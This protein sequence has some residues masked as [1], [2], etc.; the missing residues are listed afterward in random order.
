M[1]RGADLKQLLSAAAVSVIATLISLLIVK[2]VGVLAHMETITED[3]RV[4][5]IQAPM[6]QSKEIV[7]IG[8]NEET[9][10]RFPYRSPIDRAFLAD[11]LVKLEGKGPLAIGLDILLD[12]AT[13]LEK[14]RLLAK[15]IREIKVPLFISYSN[16]PAVVDQEQL[17]YLNDFVP[18]NLR[19]GANL[20]VDPF[21][22]AVRWIFPGENEPGMP[23]SFARKA[24]EAAGRP[25]PPRTQPEIAWRTVSD[26]EAP[27]FPIYPAHA[28]AALPRSWFENKI[29][30]VGA[31]LSITDKHRTPLAVVFDDE[32]G[33]M[34]GIVVMAHAV[35]QYLEGTSV[36]RL[37][38]AGQFAI[39]LMVA[40]VGVAVGLTKQG[41]AFNVTVG[42]I[43]VVLVW[44]G[45]VLGYGLGL[46][47]VPLIAP[48]LA[49]GLSLWMMD[50]LIGKAERKQ[51]QYVQGAFS[52]YVSP[53]I[54][55]QLVNDPAALSIKGKRQE[56][57]FIFTDIAGFT[58]LSE[59]L[60]SDQLSDVLNDY[61]DGACAIVQANEGTI[62]KFIGDAIMA[63]FNAPI[64]Q[65][66]HQAKAVKCALELDAYCEK[67]R[68]ENNKK[69]IPIGVTRIG[70]HAGVATIGNFGSQSRMDFTA[71]GDTV[72]A[73]ARTEGVNK[74]FG[75]RIC[76]TDTIVPNCPGMHFRVIGDVILKGK[77]TP[78]TLYNPVPADEAESELCAGYLLA[79]QLLKVGNPLAIERLKALE[80]RFPEDPLL[81]F[82]LNRIEKG[83]L[84]TLIKMEDK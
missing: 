14:D 66:D 36:R 40:V 61:L 56:A 49:L 22:S 30:L 62:D 9:L 13:E 32:R 72:N 79:Y 7:V 47:L 77:E 44:T 29:L 55:A 34:P 65:P 73:A 78:V 17:A 80:Q 46:P 6:P 2:F 8:I 24:M 57:T 25:V 59:L 67:F 63:M 23:L 70:V 60:P 3:I 41:I 27:P 69:G 53:A 18:P 50:M 83:H 54:V 20:A 45:G 19:A 42:A 15:T 21:D 74:Y 37:P 58:T 64:A 75:T 82:H 12:Q 1:T 43:I 39:V 16:T 81:K 5:A 84:S 52:R 11:L 35:S 4:A 31:I 76:C 48:T 68:V 38:L 71:V 51:R 33:M 26:L 10:S 28:V